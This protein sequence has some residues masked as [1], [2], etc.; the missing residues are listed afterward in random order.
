MSFDVVLRP[1][2][3]D[4]ALEAAEYIAANA[5]KE[6]AERWYGGLERALESLSR[7]PSR[8]AYAREHGLIAGVE[9]RQLVYHSHRLVFTIRGRTVHV[10]HIRH[11]AR[12]RLDELRL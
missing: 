6:A 4:E 3:L 8:C 9:L 5:S 2:A 1:A 11:V 10:L 12:D 7:M